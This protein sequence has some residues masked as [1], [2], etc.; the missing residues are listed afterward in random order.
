MPQLPQSYSQEAVPRS[1][2]LIFGG[3]KDTNSSVGS[4]IP[5][6]W[7]SGFHWIS[8]PEWATLFTF[9]RGVHDTHS[10]KFTSSVTPADWLLVTPLGGAQYERALTSPWMTI[11]VHIW[12]DSHD[13]HPNTVI[14][15]NTY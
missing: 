4:L 10:L 3:H 6:F 8:K 13:P 11:T 9:G 14:L 15:I 7:T 2:Y 5:L 12:S 1:F